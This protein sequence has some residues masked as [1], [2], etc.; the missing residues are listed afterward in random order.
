MAAVGTRIPG[1]VA[2]SRSGT[3]AAAVAGRIVSL[4]DGFEE[5]GTVAAGEVLVTIDAADAQAAFDRAT[6]DLADAR[7]E[8]RDADRGL[9]LARE[10]LLE[11]SPADPGKA[12]LMRDF[13]ARLARLDAAGLTRLN[14]SIH[15][16]VTSE[17]AQLRRLT[18]Q[19][20]DALQLAQTT[21]GRRHAVPRSLTLDLFERERQRVLRHG[22][23]RGY[24]AALKTGLRAA[25]VRPV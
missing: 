20:S 17:L 3:I 21:L 12:Q 8:V 5:G 2:P 15:E 25:R 22:V 24:G 6:A 18:V 16:A 13:D 10:Y 19:H 1:V 7:A 9:E 11:S 23:N 14:D 4:S